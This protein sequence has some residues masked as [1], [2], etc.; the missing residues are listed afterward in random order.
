MARRRNAIFHRFSRLRG[1]PP[2]EKMLMQRIGNLMDAALNNR[3]ASNPFEPSK[4]NPNRLL[5]PPTGLVAHTGFRTLKLTW[6]AANSDIHLRYEIRITNNE[7]GVSETKSSFT[8]ELRYKNVNG[9][10]T[11]VV[12][13]V[14]RDG[15]SSSSQTIT[16]TMGGS[17]M[18]IEGSK[19]GPTTLG[20]IVQDHI[21][22]YNNYSVYVWGSVVLDK[23]IAGSSNEQAVF[24]LYSMEGANQTFDASVATLQQTITLYAAT[25]S[26]ANLDSTAH[27]SSI[28]RPSITR[29]GT[30]ETSQ[31]V[32]FSPIAISSS[33]EEV[34]FTFFLQALGRTVELDEVNLSIVIWGGFDGLG[35]NVPQDPWDG[36]KS[37]YVFPHLHSLRIDRK[38]V[39]PSTFAVTEGA[40]YLAQQAK[41]FNIIDN[42]WTIAVWFRLETEHVELLND[43]GD[44]TN[45]KLATS[46]T[47][48]RRSSYNSTTPYNFNENAIELK[49]VAGEDQFGVGTNTIN[50]TVWP[51][52]GDDSEKLQAEFTTVVFGT[53]ADPD[54]DDDSNLWGRD[55]DQAAHNYNWQLVVI[56]F[57]GGPL[58]SGTSLTPKIRMY[59][60]N[61]LP[62]NGNPDDRQV[63][64]NAMCCLNQRVADG[65]ANTSQFAPSNLLDEGDQDLTNDYVYSVGG[66]GPPT[67]MFTNGDYKGDETKIGNGTF[68]IHQAGMWN[69]AID[70]WDGMGFNPGTAEQ[71]DSSPWYAVP[72]GGT[73]PV[74]NPLLTDGRENVTVG[75]SLTAIHY[76]YN[77]GYGTDIDWKKN[78]IARPDGALEYIFAENLIHLWQFGAIPDEYSE[79]AE[80]LRDTGNYLFGGGVNFLRK[81]SNTT[82]TGG[83]SSNLWSEDTKLTDIL[84]P[85]RINAEL[86]SEW[87]NPS[88][89]AAKFPP[90]EWESAGDSRPSFDNQDGVV[91]PAGHLNGAGFSDAGT[92][93]SRWAYPGFGFLV[94][95]VNGGVD[96]GWRRPNVTLGV[97][98]E[99]KTWGPIHYSFLGSGDGLGASGLEQAEIDTGQTAWP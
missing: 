56:C 95:E 53:H 23:F 87:V 92:T 44:V 41:E 82:L 16:F 55:E 5:Y 69:I 21:T 24:K 89:S 31:S 2:D 4:N 90:M 86:P 9:A 77:Q 62:V 3:Q 45:A 51:E 7:T 52:D 91:Q 71:R 20:T 99:P 50:V 32:M 13:S 36:G 8:N 54:E 94:T 75:S 34:T 84:S 29:P 12:K 88:T 17:V 73:P 42:A 43:N 57:E 49:L 97:L 63:P 38:A 15:S 85:V 39:N 11:A 93:A 59:T 68:T 33:E 6:T 1:L 98:D 65:A 35:D 74:V 37:G 19:N 47:I 83:G 80:T 76:L 70:N 79:T 27:S 14:G 10:Y 58:T 61:R 26:F 30:F 67:A 18:Q 46:S 22:V 72:Y 60:P 78:S 28:T 40:W 25:E 66:P 64:A 81:W 48:F 96:V